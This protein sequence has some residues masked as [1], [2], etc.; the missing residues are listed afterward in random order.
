MSNRCGDQYLI[1]KEK[2]LNDQITFAS[3]LRYSRLMHVNL[4]ASNL[5]RIPEFVTQP[6]VIL[7]ITEIDLSYNSILFLT[8]SV[9]LKFGHIRFLNLSSNSIHIIPSSIS[10]MKSMHSL[11]LSNNNLRSL[12]LSLRECILLTNL[13]LGGNK[14][15]EFPAVLLKMNLIELEIGHNYL[16]SLPLEIR[17]LENLSTFICCNNMLDA[18]PS[19]FPELRKIKVLDIR[20]NVIGSFSLEL[21]RLPCITV[22]TLWGNPCPYVQNIESGIV[23]GLPEEWRVALPQLLAAGNPPKK[24]T[25]AKSVKNSSTHPISQAES[26]EITAKFSA[27]DAIGCIQP[28]SEVPVNVLADTKD[29]NDARVME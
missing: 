2:K 23:E 16:K 27:A 5:W 22:L 8:N 6:R 18:L 25:Q 26:V 11:D 4:K 1:W 10:A 24:T 20:Y 17:A 12:P 13:K 19:T 28:H 15:S 29:G 3:A 7:C 14:F 9:L 21:F